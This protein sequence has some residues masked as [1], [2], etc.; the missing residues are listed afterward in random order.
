MKNITEINRNELATFYSMTE[1]VNSLRKSQKVWSWGAR[2]W[3]NM[4]YKFLKFRVS[5]HLF[6]GVV[7][8]GVNG[9]DL[10]DVYLTNL[11]GSIQHE[12]NDVYVEDLIDTIDGKVEKIAAYAS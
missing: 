9:K 10:F 1:L 5:G 8:I 7:Y 2:G 3:T 6:K 4:E 11:R 12:I